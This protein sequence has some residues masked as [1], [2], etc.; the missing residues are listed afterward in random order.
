[1]TYV[2][3]DI[4]YQLWKFGLLGKDFHYRIF[5]AARPAPL[6]ATTSQPDAAAPTPA[7]RPR[8]VG[9]QRH[10]HAP[11]VP[12]EAAEAGAGGAGLSRT[13]GAFDPLLLRDGGALPSRPR[14][15]LATTPRKTP[16]SPFVEV[17]GRKGLGVKAD[18]LLDRLRDKAAVEVAKRNPEL[19]EADA[20]QIAESH[21]HGRRALLHGEVLTRQ[22]HRF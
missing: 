1:M 14:A 15:S 17:S 20:K 19:P 8:G 18:D 2:G 9:L 10:R 12:A 4:A 22:G 13:G 11:V 5:D 7:V 21:R 16:T 6:W 3:K